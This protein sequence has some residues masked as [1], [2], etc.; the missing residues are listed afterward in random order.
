MRKVLL[1]NLVQGERTLI[2]SFV[3]MKKGESRVTNIVSRDDLWPNCKNSAMKSLQQHLVGIDR[4]PLALVCLALLLLAPA[5]ATSVPSSSS[6]EQEAQGSRLSSGIVANADVSDP[7][8][9]ATVDESRSSA[10][11]SLWRQRTVDAVREASSSGF[12]LGPG[13]VL[14]ISVPQIPQL[15][16]RTERVSEENTIALPLLGVIDVHGMTQQDLLSDLTHRVR[17]YMYHPE[18]AVFLMHSEN[19]DVA[20]LGAVKTPGRYMMTSRS[21]SIMTMISRS[22]GMTVE[23][24]SRIILVPASATSEQGSTSDGSSS[25]ATRRFEDSDASGSSVSSVALHESTDLDAVAK[26]NGFNQVIILTSDKKDQ[27]Y[28]ELPV[29]PGD[30]IIVPAAGQVTVQGWVDKPGAFP[31]TPGLTALGSIAAAG[32]ALFTSSATLL[33]ERG[34]DRKLEVPLDLTKIKRGE[35]PDIPVQGGDV[36]VVERSVAGAVPYSLYF[37]AQRIGLGV[38]IIP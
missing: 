6:S 11:E 7:A 17:K 35:E 37:L 32:G 24:A 26:H 3:R 9:L 16:D 12:Y 34:N 8:N 20:V 36:V 2:P 10:L 5:C 33:R 1:V 30:V 27:R 29:E 25:F 4:S 18:V 19:R 22:G 21:D 14:K 28:L 13:D 23:A 38:P 15:K 31:V